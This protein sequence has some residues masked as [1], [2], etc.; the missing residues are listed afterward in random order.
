MSL[1][2]IAH[3]YFVVEVGGGEGANCVCRPIMMLSIYLIGC[4]ANGKLKCASS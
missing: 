4:L 3:N 1:I 2:N